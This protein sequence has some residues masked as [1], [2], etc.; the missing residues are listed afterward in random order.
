MH[1]PTTRRQWTGFLALVF[2]VVLAVLITFAVAL[3]L[4]TQTCACY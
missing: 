4:A 2:G 3:A 1:E